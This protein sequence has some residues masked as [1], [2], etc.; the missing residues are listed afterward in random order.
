MPDEKLII[1]KYTV[2]SLFIILITGEIDLESALILFSCL[3]YQVQNPVRLE[4]SV[5]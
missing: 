5:S 1:W 3:H 2:L 4:A